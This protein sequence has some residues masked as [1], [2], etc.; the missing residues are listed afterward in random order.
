MRSGERVREPA[1]PCFGVPIDKDGV[2]KVWPHKSGP[3][4]GKVGASARRRCRLLL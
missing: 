2:Y 4:L 3:N 1:L